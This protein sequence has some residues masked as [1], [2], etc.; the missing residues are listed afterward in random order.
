MIIAQTFFKTFQFQF[1]PTVAL[2]INTAQVLPNYHEQ[3][4]DFSM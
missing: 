2:Y 1:T 3:F 4:I